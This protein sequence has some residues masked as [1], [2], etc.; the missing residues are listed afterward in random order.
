VTTHL[1]DLT[2]AGRLA[3]ITVRGHAPAPLSSATTTGTV[4]LSTSE[5]SSIDLTIA[6]PDLDV[7]RS[8]VFAKGSPVR[9]AG[10]SQFVV[11]TLEVSADAGAPQLAVTCLS[12]G[13]QQARA[14]YG[15]L[16]RHSLSPS[17][18]VAVGA[19]AVG[20]KAVCEPSADRSSITRTGPS[21]DS[22]GDKGESEYDVWQRLA[23]EVGYI[24]FE[25]N[26]TV[27]FGRPSWLI[28]HVAHVDVRWPSDGRLLGIP[29]CR[30]TTTDDT[31]PATISIACA[32]SLAYLL[33][34]GAC[35][36]LAGVPTFD[37]PYLVTQCQIPLDDTTACSVD[38]A[39]P[40]DPTPQP[41]AKDSTGSASGSSSSK[42]ASSTGATDFMHQGG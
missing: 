11:T 6:D 42:K 40:V 21:K 29:R 28:D 39:S 13:A 10:L 16:V 12:A 23:G 30:A 15:Q 17:S 3:A 27:Y 25:A 35:A 34:P 18:Y 22:P 33:V 31:Q 20:L 2:P 7:L 41:P 36:A 37:A 24:C 8:G 38:A 9:Y 26:G 19:T 1:P 4:T 14:Q 5:V 32:E